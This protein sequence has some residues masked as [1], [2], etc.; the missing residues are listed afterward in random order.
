VPFEALMCGTPVVVSDDCG[1]GQ[2]IKSAQAGYTVPYGDV[3]ALAQ[4][5]Y[6]IFANGEEAKQKV[7]AGQQF[8]RENLDWNK[9]TNKLIDLYQECIQ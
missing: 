1:M 8:I 2:I 4:A 9:I 5:L 6:H 3:E 7:V